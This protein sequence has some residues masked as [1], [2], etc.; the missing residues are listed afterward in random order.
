MQNSI[1]NKTKTAKEERENDRE[2]G[3]LMKICENCGELV[4][5]NI[6]VNCYSDVVISVIS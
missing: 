1:R 3:I 2:I 5:E 4:E 6:C